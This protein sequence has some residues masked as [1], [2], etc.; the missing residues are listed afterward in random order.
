MSEHMLHKLTFKF[1]LFQHK[2]FFLQIKG[3]SIIHK[4]KLWVQT[5]DHGEVYTIQ[6]I[7]FACDLQPVDG[8]LRVL[9]FPPSRRPTAMI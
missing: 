4:V 1:S 7:M 9:W 3:V 5:P 6:Y 8:F 2:Y